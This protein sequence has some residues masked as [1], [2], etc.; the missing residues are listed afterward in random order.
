[1]HCISP[2]ALSLNMEK[3]TVQQVFGQCPYK[4]AEK[5]EKRE[6][7]NRESQSERAIN[8]TRC[9]WNPN[10][11]NHPPS[12][13][14]ENLQDIAMKETRAFLAHNR[15]MNPFIIIFTK[16]TNLANKGFIQ[17]NNKFVCNHFA[18]RRSEKRSVKS[19]SLKE[20]G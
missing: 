12:S 9:N 19:P 10:N 2:I 15:L 4:N 6:V 5:H 16:M 1:M 14:R 7:R 20:G 18:T 17:I 3:K 11:W 13:S 8:E